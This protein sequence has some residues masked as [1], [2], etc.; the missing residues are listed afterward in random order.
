MTSG[1]VV[2]AVEN[3]ILRFAQ[4][5]KRFGGWGGGERDP[6]LRSG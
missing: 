5:D 3:E 6:S 1:L 2:G 4:D